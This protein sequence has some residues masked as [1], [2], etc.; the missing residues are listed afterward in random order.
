M[1]VDDCRHI[2]ANSASRFQRL[3]SVLWPHLA[4]AV[5]ACGRNAGMPQPLLYFGDIGFMIQRIGRRRT[6]SLAIEE[7][8][9]LLHLHHFDPIALSRPNARE[10]AS[11]AANA[12]A[13]GLF[14]IAEIYNQGGKNSPWR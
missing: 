1:S 12:L 10:H 6:A 9:R 11:K 8:R 4:P 7:S 5:D 13:G 14:D 3:C 2:F